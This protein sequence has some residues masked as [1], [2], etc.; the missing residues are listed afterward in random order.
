M[1]SNSTRKLLWLEISKMLIALKKKFIV[2]F[3]IIFGTLSSPT[4]LLRRVHSTSTELELAN[5]T[6]EH[7]LFNGTVRGTRSAV[8]ELQCEQSH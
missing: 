7:M 5:Y 2:S 3:I 4:A 1:L 6:S 8:C